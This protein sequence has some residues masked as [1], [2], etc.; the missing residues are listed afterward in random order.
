MV[1]VDVFSTRELHLEG[2]RALTIKTPTCSTR[3]Y[4]GTIITG[5]MHETLFNRDL[6]IFDNCKDIRFPHQLAAVSE[7]DSSIVEG[8]KHFLTAAE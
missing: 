6:I 1:V 7:P 4:G 8:S 3:F 2:I 5:S